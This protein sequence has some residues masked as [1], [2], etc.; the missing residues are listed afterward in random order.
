V[1]IAVYRDDNAQVPMIIGKV[2]GHPRRKPEG[3]TAEV[4]YTRIEADDG[5][6]YEYPALL[7]G[8]P[9]SPHVKHAS[10]SAIDSLANGRAHVGRL[11]WEFPN[12]ANDENAGEGGSPEDL[13]TLAKNMQRAMSFARAVEE[14]RRKKELSA[15][16]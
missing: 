4:L 8:G 16:P 12:F 13:A 9:K 5:S 1:P 3:L 11:G 14:R 2:V 10:F 7:G 15:R 6:V